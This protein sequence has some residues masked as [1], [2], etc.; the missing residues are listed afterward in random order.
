MLKGSGGS[1]QFVINRQQV[2][3]VNPTSRLERISASRAERGLFLNDDGQPNIM[4]LVKVID[5][6]HAAEQ[7]RIGLYTPNAQAGR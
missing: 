6:N 7:D 4:Q 3:T 2:A 1:V 5:A